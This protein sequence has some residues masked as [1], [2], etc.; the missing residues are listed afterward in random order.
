MTVQPVAESCNGWHPSDII[1]RHR[2]A[3]APNPQLGHIHHPHWGL[4]PNPPKAVFPMPMATMLPMI[5]A[6][7]G[8]LLGTLK[9]SKMPVMMAD[10]ST[11][12]GSFF[13][14]YFVSANSTTTQLNTESKVT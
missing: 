7:H 3:R 2:T 12:V 10:P 6:H 13:S 9:A 8:R 11:I 5:I 1:Q 4:F 14:K